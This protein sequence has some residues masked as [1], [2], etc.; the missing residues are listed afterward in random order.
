ME[1][2]Q[3]SLTESAALLTLIESISDFLAKKGEVPLTAASYA[4]L[5]VTFS[6]LLQ[7]KDLGKLNLQWNAMT[8]VTNLLIGHFAFGETLSGND[9]VG[10]A[11][12]LT[13]MFLLAQGK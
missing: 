3:L 4:A 8:N 7:N 11:L 13:G 9:T 12:I 2:S 1:L 10:V 5:G 6:K